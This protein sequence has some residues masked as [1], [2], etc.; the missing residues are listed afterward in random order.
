M[1]YAQKSTKDQ[2]VKKKYYTSQAIHLISIPWQTIIS[3][4]GDNKCK[5]GSLFLHSCNFCFA[6]TFILGRAWMRAH[7]CVLTFFH[8]HKSSSRKIEFSV[9]FMD[10]PFHVCLFFFLF[11]IIQEWV[12]EQRY[13]NYNLNN[14]KPKLFVIYV[15]WF[16]KFSFYQTKWDWDAIGGRKCKQLFHFRTIMLLIHLSIAL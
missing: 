13:Q 7:G 1:H 9:Y 2:T 3:R 8:S 16:C 4:A 5:C 11:F 15:E 12:L 10:I 6:P 14:R